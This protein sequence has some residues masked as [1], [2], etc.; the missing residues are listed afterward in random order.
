MHLQYLFQFNLQYK[1]R[2]NNEKIYI[3]AHYNNE[4]DI[5]SDSCYLDSCPIA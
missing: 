1:L 4:A 5:S 2:Y 3:T